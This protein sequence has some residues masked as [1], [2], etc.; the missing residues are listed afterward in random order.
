[1]MKKLFLSL[2]FPP[3]MCETAKFTQKSPSFPHD[4]PSVGGREST[5]AKGLK[6]ANTTSW[7]GKNEPIDEPFFPSQPFGGN[8]SKIQSMSER[9]SFEW[10]S[11]R[12]SFSQERN[13]NATTQ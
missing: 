12:R 5:N 1:M 3:S 11:E 4:D 13:K 2:R 10:C 6:N 8:N 9:R 7:K